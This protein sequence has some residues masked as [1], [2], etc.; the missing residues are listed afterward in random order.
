MTAI[1]PAP[2]ARI[3]VTGGA[4]FL[5]H[6]L[7]KR[8]LDLGHEV[9]VLDDLSTG[10]RSNLPSDPRLIFVE[11]SILNPADCVK[12]A[13]GCAATFH[14]AAIVGMRLAA[15]YQEASYNIAD[16]GTRHVLDATGDTPIIL[17]S[18]SA[19]YGLTTQAAV[20]EHETVGEANCL[21]YDGGKRGYASGKWR[22]E[23][24]GQEAM[25]AGRKV[26]I[27]RPFNA[28]GEGQV[29]TYGMV[30]PSFIQQALSNADIT[31]YDDGLQSRTFSEVK[32]FVSVLD[33][34][35]HTPAAWD[36]PNNVVN[37]GTQ[38]STTIRGLAELVLETTGSSSTLSFRPYSDVFPGKSDVRARV[39]NTSRLESLIG[40][41]QWPSLAEIVQELV[42]Q[43][44]NGQEAPAVTA[45]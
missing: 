8:L 29:G 33:R 3:L 26:L 24:L 13:A 11:G 27:V 5:G 39:P 18:S 9:V 20:A 44:R 6:Q 15:A 36:A 16:A 43:A 7:V 34:L 22:L 12:A 35:V 42:R 30:V 21:A 10:K 14:L 31:I 2:P 28:V 4:G 37:V 45:S 17:F 41:V 25:Q 32:C 1:F 23:E 40:P 19:V 38:E